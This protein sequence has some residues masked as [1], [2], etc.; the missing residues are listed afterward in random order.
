MLRQSVHY[1]VKAEHPNQKQYNQPVRDM[2]PK[3]LD[4]YK[5]LGTKPGTK[6]A[7][8]AWVAKFSETIFSSSATAAGDAVAAALAEGMSAD[9]IGEAISL[10]ANQLLLRDNG[11]PKEWTQPNKPVGSVHGDSIGVHACDTVH[12]WRNL[13][14]AGDRRTQVTSLILAGYQVARDRGNRAEFLKWDPYPRADAQ[15]KVKSVAADALMKELDAAIRD[16]DQARTAALTARIGIE[17]PGQ[18]R[19]KCS[20]FCGTSRSARTARFT[21]RSTTP[22]PRTSSPA[23]GPRSG[24]GNSWPS[25]A[26]PPASTA[27][28]RQASRKR[29]SW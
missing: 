2:L 12:A 20:R 29:A 24:G 17:K 19:R 10:A 23:R 7:D 25:P 6:S 3:L 27:T 26:S 4:Q 13:A 21:P 14:A 15:E 11:R 18:R 5:L 28:R 1:C 9:A 16:K 22:P 8:D